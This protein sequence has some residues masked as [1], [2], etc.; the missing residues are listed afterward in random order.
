MA[1]ALTI[2]RAS[3]AI[4]DVATG[5]VTISVIDRPPV[6]ADDVL[7]SVANAQG[8]TDVLA[9]KAD[10]STDIGDGLRMGTDP[11]RTLFVEPPRQRGKTLRG[12]HLAHRGGA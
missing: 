9:K 11:D 10:L 4:T 3:A 2:E 7:T 6:A 12:E 8:Q 5:A 1:G